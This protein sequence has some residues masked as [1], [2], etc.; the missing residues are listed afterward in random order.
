M[1]D[2][3]MPLVLLHSGLKKHSSEVHTNSLTSG[4]RESGTAVVSGSLLALL[5]YR[6]SSTL[7]YRSPQ[8]VYC[9]VVLSVWDHCLAPEMHSNKIAAG[10]FGANKHADPKKRKRPDRAA[11][12]CSPCSRAREASSPAFV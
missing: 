8:L 2:G 3:G 1:R 7:D 6:L 11:R 4:C 12:R 5:I 9:R 10:I